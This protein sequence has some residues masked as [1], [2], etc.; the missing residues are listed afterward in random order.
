MA[1]SAGSGIGTAIGTIGGLIGG[2]ASFGVSIVI[3]LL[4]SLFGGLFGGPDVGA[5][6]AA[7]QS[8][9]SAL[10]NAVDTLTRFAWTIAAALGS[11]LK[12]LYGLLIGFLQHVWDLIKQL[13]SQ[14]AKIIKQILPQ[15]L[16]AIKNARAFLD[17]VYK[18]FIRPILNYLQYIRRFLV[19]LQ[20]FHVK[21]A[22]KLDA[23]IGQ[24]ES[25][26]L[27]P[28]FYVYRALNGIGTWINL[29]VTVGG[30]IQRAVFVNTMYA[31]QADWVNIFWTGQT[32]GGLTGA[33]P[34]P[35]ASPAVETWDQ[36]KANL[37]TYAQTGGGPVA[38]DAQAAQ[39]AL[40]SVLFT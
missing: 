1:T 11:L 9:R 31:Y 15:I 18:T 16:Q 5:I 6:N 19:I 13:F 8:L 24:I 35:P 21:F 28:F 26:I 27:A 32:A 23:W 40:Q 14:L 17:Y 29:V 33:P 12:F 4:G 37:T 39:S 3:G 36:T 10:S 2:L 20:L 38:A 7:L 34:T 30:I 25:R 22:A